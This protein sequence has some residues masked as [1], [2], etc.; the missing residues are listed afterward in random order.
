VIK[1]EV[2]YLK[3]LTPADFEKYNGK[4]DGKIVCIADQIPV[5]LS[6]DRWL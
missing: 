6:Q 5:R 1:S 2:V 3:A 4:L